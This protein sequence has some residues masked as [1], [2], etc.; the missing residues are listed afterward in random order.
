MPTSSVENAD[1]SVIRVLIADDHAVV[2][3]G[4]RMLISGEPDL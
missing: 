2:S 1:A 4:L 3:N